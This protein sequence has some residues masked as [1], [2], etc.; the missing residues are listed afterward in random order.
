[1]TSTSSLS[2]A[3]AWRQ[4]GLNGFCAA[5]AAEMVRRKDER[6]RREVLV[7]AGVTDEAQLRSADYNDLV[8]DVV[9]LSREELGYVRPVV[10]LRSEAAD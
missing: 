2:T 3:S 6:L 4:R 5:G 8:T 9:F 10:A 7:C 1:M